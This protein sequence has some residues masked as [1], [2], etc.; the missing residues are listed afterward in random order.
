[1][2][3]HAAS[4]VPGGASWQTFE[5]EWTAVALVDTTPEGGTATSFERTP[6]SG[7]TVVLGASQAAVEE[8]TRGVAGAWSGHEHGHVQVVIAPDGTVD[9]STDGTGTIP[10]FWG[11]TDG[12]FAFATHLASLV[13]LGVSPSLD[14]V[15]SMEYLVMLHPLG[16]RTV[17]AEASLLPPGGR[18][19]A[20]PGSAPKLSVQPLYV[21]SGE[22][23]GD[24]EAVHEFAQLWSAI[25]DD[26]LARTES[27]RLAVGLSGGLDSRAIGVESSRRGRRLHAFTYGSSVTKPARVATEVARILQLDHTLLPLSD[28]RLMPRPAEM[29]SRLD[30]AHSP[31]EMYELWF[32]PTLKGF[33]DVVVNGKAGGILWGDEK[34]LGINDSATLLGVLER[35]YARE[36]AAMAPFL[37]QGVS[38]SARDRLRSSLRDSLAD[39]DSGVRSDMVTFWNVHNR[40]FRWGNMLSTALRRSGLYLEAPFM[41]ARFLRFSSRLTPAQR[42]NGRLHLRV[43]RELFSRTAD[44]PRSDD[45][46]SPRRLNHVYWSGEPSLATQFAHL[47]REHPVSAMRRASGR[48]QGNVAKRL[49][50]APRLSRV[51]DQYATRQ[52]V[53]AAD[54]WLRTNEAYRGRLVDFLGSSTPPPMISSQAV[55]RAVEALSA[56]AV[57]TGAL[58]LARVATLLAWSQDFSRRA[59]ARRSS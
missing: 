49:G 30:G 25:T 51:G 23:M 31:A 54:V 56:G 59:T 18:L 58:R 16:T 6:A 27:Q 55:E 4:Q 43:H 44:V 13:S 9:I 45:G 41:D 22:V 39:W 11:D 46:N 32:G 35:R 48:F 29:A 1:M 12:G 53:F 3:E 52:S 2:L 40:Q 14:E 38:G 17:L 19:Q 24:T 10:S 47:A 33:A 21:P 7:L 34:A 36:V 5:D 28:D 20:S 26:M 42:M 50:Q 15:A 37:E 57:P 8:V